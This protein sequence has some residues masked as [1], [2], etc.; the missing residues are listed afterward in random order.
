MGVG[1]KWKEAKV[2]HKEAQKKKDRTD[3][4]SHNGDLQ[5]L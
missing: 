2:K 4:K 5:L 1:N 3:S